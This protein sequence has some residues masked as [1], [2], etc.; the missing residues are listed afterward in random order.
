[1]TAKTTLPAGWRSAKLGDICKQDRNL[2]DPKSSIAGKLTY[3][4]LEHIESNSGR[5]LREPSEPISDEGRSTTYFFDNRH[6]LY[7]KLRPYLNKVALPDFEGRCTTEL[8]P[9]LPKSIDREF[10]A[11]I[12]RRKET[13]DAAMQE[14]TG[15]RM[16]RANMDDL[17]ALEIPLPPLAEQ[18]RIAARLSEQMTSVAQARQAAEEQL[19]LLDDLINAYLRD[20]LANQTTKKLLAECFIEVKKGVGK[21]WH[22]YPVIG[23]TRVGV[24]P[25]KEKV[26]KQPERYKLVEPGTILY[27]PMRIN[28]GSIAVLDE[29]DQPGITSPD[30]VVFKSIEGIVHFRWFYYWLRSLYGEAF[31]KTLARGAVRERM[32]FNRLVN[33]EIELPS[34][35]VQCQ[36]AEK[37]KEIR[38]LRQSLEAQL[39]EIN[40]LPSALL[41]RAFSGEM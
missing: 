25:A 40:Q 19:G 41:R 11:W 36:V 9:I 35:E 23:A 24:A 15:S 4:S 33:G 32:L 14:K 39:A 7:G 34:W 1:M 21:T 2:I 17:F 38:A 13:V 28:I 29:G 3:L 6:V 30:Y 10:L 5:I 12:L 37:L 31:I 27:N 8:I 20:S 26:G 16:P 18:Q 22:Q